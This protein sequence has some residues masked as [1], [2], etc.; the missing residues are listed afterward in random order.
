[1]RNIYRPP[2]ADLLNKI[3]IFYPYLAPN[4]AV[5]LGQDVGRMQ[6]K[7]SKKSRRD[8]TFLLTTHQ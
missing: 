4:G 1:M 8:G 6:I 2:M 7:A 5:P 3:V